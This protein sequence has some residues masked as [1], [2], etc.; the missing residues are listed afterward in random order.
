MPYV[1]QG[2]PKRFDIDDYLARYPFI[3]WSIPVLQEEVRL[4]DQT[5][6]WRS[7][8]FA[9]AVAIGRISEL[10]TEIRHLQHPEALGDDLW[11]TEIDE[12]SVIKV[13]IT[14]NE[15]H[16]SI[17]E[18]MITR[19]V[20]K[21]DPVLSKNRIIT[22]PQGTVFRLSEEEFDQFLVHW[23]NPGMLAAG[24]EV[25]SAVEGATKLRTHYSRERSRFLVQKKRKAF[26]SEHGQLKCE[27][28]GLSEGE[29][30]PQEFGTPFIEVHHKKPL[31]SAPSE[32][33]TN[34]DDLVLLCANCHR[35][36]H[37]TKDVEHNF[38]LL[39]KHYAANI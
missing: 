12:P 14:I 39:C 19:E 10:P 15:V 4:N 29:K 31:S 3:Y 9:G 36:I 22:N 32:V 28:C 33:R 34:L 24:T 11:R 17:E 27:I 1:F 35:V 26:F 16:L 13:G 38:E 7:G 8:E 21:K 6:I 18:G 25:Q 20:L 37:S 30:Y 2:D 5:I 23:E